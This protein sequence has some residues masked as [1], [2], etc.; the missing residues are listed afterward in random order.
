VKYAIIADIH[1]HFGALQAVMR[2]AEQQGCTHTACLGDSVGYWDKPKECVDIIRAMGMTC[3]KGNY[4]E[5]CSNATNLE[6]FNPPA[7]EVIRWTRSQLTEDDRHWLRNLPLVANVA[8]FTLVHGSL[9]EPAKW[10]Y[11]FDGLA[12]AASFTCQ[13]TAVCFF[14]HTHVPVSFARD[15]VVRGGTYSKL[16]I[17]PGRKYFINVGSVGQPRDG[18]PKAAYV[19]QDLEERS[20]DLRRVDSPPPV[21]PPGF[22]GSVPASSPPHG[23]KPHLSGRGF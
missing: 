16:K 1:A 9:K 15:S 23:P 12:A 6:G 3:V 19:T 10:G 22:G 14:G 17:E 18:N 21:F 13:K 20:I 4:D 7:A 11:V 2:D 5:Y 8:G